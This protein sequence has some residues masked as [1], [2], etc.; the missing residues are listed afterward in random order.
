MYVNVYRLKLLIYTTIKITSDVYCRCNVDF[1]AAVTSA[2]DVATSRQ[3]AVQRALKAE[4]ELYRASAEGASRD[5]C[6]QM[7]WES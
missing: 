2:S 4:R 5:R 1:I 6:M 3:G 7:D